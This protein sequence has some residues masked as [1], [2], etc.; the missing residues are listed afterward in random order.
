M[1]LDAIPEEVW[2]EWDHP[3]HIHPERI[4]LF[5]E[6][7]V[8]QLLDVKG[9]VDDQGR[10]VRCALCFPAA[11]KSKPKVRLFVLRAIARLLRV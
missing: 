1:G 11:P 8:D 9:N 5:N 3:N 2:I 4:A 6:S 7:Q 10:D